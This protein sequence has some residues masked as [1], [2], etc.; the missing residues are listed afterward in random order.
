MTESTPATISHRVIAQSDTYKLRRIRIPDDASG[1][2]EQR[3]AA[4]VAELTAR[5]AQELSGD[6]TVVAAR[7]AITLERA[8][9]NRAVTYLTDRDVPC[10]WASPLFCACYA[11]VVRETVSALCP[12][13]LARIERGEFLPQQVP[14]MSCTEVNPGRWREYVRGRQRAIAKQ[15]EV[16]LSNVTDRFQCH[17]CKERKCSYFERQT[18]SADEPMTVFITCVLCNNSWTM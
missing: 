5:I 8:A 7:M 2:A 4:S 17:R 3:R 6:D 9:Y 13:L 11:M 15:F 10:T 18:R 14:F 16:D 1:S 12:Q